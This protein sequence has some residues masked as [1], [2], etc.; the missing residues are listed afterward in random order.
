M[1]LL[2]LFRRSPEKKNIRFGTRSTTFTLHNVTPAKRPLP[3]CKPQE[4]VATLLTTI[5]RNQRDEADRPSELRPKLEACCDYSTDCVA[6]IDFHPLVAAVHYAYSEHRPLVL[7]PDMIWVTILQG[8][9]QHVRHNPERLRDKFVQHDGKRT[10]QAVRGDVVPGS[11]E[12][13]WPEVIQDWADGVQRHL[14]DNHDRLVAEFSTTGNHDQ[15]AATIALLDAVSPYFR[16]EVHF[17]CGIPEI[18]IEGVPDDWGLLRSKVDG[19]KLFELDWWLPHLRV[20][21]DQFVRASEGKIDRDHWEEIYYPFDATG[22]CITKY[23]RRRRRQQPSSGRNHHVDV[24]GWIFRLFPYLRSNNLDYSRRNS[25]L[26]NPDSC[27]SFWDIPGGLSTT[28]FECHSRT[29]RMKE[30]K[31][32]VGGFVGITQEEKTFALRPKLG[33]AV[34]DNPATTAQ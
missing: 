31:R 4:S 12:N 19:L 20:I 25:L 14:G 22:E 30:S 13:L 26:E 10:I 24:G 5:D 9:S 33:W 2:S 3:I 34:C 7:S 18:K 6:G 11:P 32:L 16:F 23:T 17:I 27:L 1:N 8:L 28:P 21:C 29:R 15:L